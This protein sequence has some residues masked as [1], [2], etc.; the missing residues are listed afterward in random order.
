MFS[1]RA[2]TGQAPRLTRKRKCQDCGRPAT[3]APPNA[4]R[5]RRHPVTGDDRHDLCFRC[6]KRRMSAA[7]R[8]QEA[9]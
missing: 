9:A 7:E 6:F 4:H 5:R 8:E 1:P 2:E 3:Y